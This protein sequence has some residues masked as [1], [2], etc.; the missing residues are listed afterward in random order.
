MYDLNRRISDQNQVIIFGP[1][2]AMEQHQV[3]LFCSPHLLSSIS[4][5]V[6]LLFL[7]FRSKDLL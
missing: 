7:G 3:T 4:F 6:A 5:C 2:H 1:N